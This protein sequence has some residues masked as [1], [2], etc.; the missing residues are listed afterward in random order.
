MTN[1]IKSN[2]VPSFWAIAG[3]VAVLTICG[4]I[5]GFF[6]A[7]YPERPTW[8]DRLGVAVWVFIVVMD[9]FM[10]A[11]SVGRWL[12]WRSR[13]VGYMDHTGREWAVLEEAYG[14]GPYLECRWYGT[15]PLEYVNRTWGPLE[16]IYR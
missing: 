15:Y 1:R 14:D 4:A 7:T 6:I 16:P 3:Q 10:V 13:P 2:G 9:M 11:S 8:L 12:R 5:L